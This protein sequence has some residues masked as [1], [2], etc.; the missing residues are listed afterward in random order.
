MLC[1]LIYLLGGLFSGAVFMAIETRWPC[2]RFEGSYPDG[3]AYRSAMV[4]GMFLCCVMVWP[5]YWFFVFPDVFHTR[6]GRA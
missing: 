2:P 1:L 4:W 3:L 5:L 6:N